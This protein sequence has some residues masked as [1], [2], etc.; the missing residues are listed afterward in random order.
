[1]TKFITPVSSRSHAAPRG[2]APQSG[3]FQRHAT[4]VCCTPYIQARIDA[5]IAK[6][7]VFCI[8]TAASATDD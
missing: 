3:M 2:P 7:N 1:M 4:D 5:Q 8:H 6:F